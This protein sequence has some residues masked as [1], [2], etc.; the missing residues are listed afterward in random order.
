MRKIAMAL[1][2]V[3]AAA[4]A[5]PVKFWTLEEIAGKSDVLAV[6]EVLDTRKVRSVPAAQSRFGCAINERS[7][8]VRVLRVHSQGGAPIGLKRGEVLAIRYWAIDWTKTQG[9]ANGPSFPD[10]RKGEIH[11]FPLRRREGAGPDR[12]ELLSDEDFNLLV[13]AA[14]KRLPVDNI[15]MGI[16]FLRAELAGA[17][18][19]GRYADIVRAGEYLSSMHDGAALAPISRL[20]AKQVGNDEERWLDIAV[21]CYCAMPLQRSGIDDLLRDGKRKRPLERLIATALVEAGDN[22]LDARIIAKAIEHAPLHAWGTG[23]TLQQNYPRHPVTFER[24]G[25]ALA[26]G[27]PGALHV[28]RTLVRD[29]EHPLLP[30]ALPAARRRLLV[31]ERLERSDWGAFGTLRPA[32]ELIRDYGSDDDLAVLVDEVRRAQKADRTR[33]VMLWVSLAYTKSR[34]LLPICRVMIDDTGVFSG[35]IRFCDAAAAH[36]AVISGEGFGLIS[37]PSRE[38]QD[39]IVAKAKA[40][41]EQNAR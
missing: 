6:A 17:L 7:A 11:V 33:Y 34:R 31:R 40:W 25:E 41:L 20:V 13:P 3:V 14:R 16:E 36:V 26:N 23:I 19:K 24:L 15:D 27:V 29:A 12:F 37:N 35:K 28:A 39:R 8:R 32:C 5:R 2:L 38:E 1:A 10:F 4:G 18:A 9:I 22:G 30:A 21:A